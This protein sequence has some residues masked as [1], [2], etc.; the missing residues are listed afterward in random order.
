MPSTYRVLEAILLLL[1]LAA[2]VIL[3]AGP[4]QLGY[5]LAPTAR[6]AR[7][8]QPHISKRKPLS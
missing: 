5:W 6:H 3:S 4:R 7:A 8:V 1:Q 2:M